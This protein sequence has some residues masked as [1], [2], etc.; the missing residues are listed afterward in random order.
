M[1]TCPQCRLQ[2]CPAWFAVDCPS[3]PQSWCSMV[4]K[5]HKQNA[6]QDSNANLPAGGVHPPEL[7]CVWTKLNGKGRKLLFIMLWGYWWD[8]Q[9]S[10]FTPSQDIIIFEAR[11]P[12]KVT[13]PAS[14]PRLHVP[15]ERTHIQPHVRPSLPHRPR[16]CS[17]QPSSALTELPLLFCCSPIWDEKAQCG[18]RH[19]RE[20]PKTE[21]MLKLEEEPGRSI[22]RKSEHKCFIPETDHRKSMNLHKTTGW[23]G[24][25]F[26]LVPCPSWIPIHQG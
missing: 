5:R 8:T 24:E 1:R 20:K 22:P 2:T 13:C 12:L 9:W 21:I 15:V 11:L 16:R 14:F 7:C 17:N 18:E 6:L 26:I 3:P 10:Y 4:H 25:D 23:E 19:M